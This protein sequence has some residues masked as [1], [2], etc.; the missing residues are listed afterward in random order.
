M[1]ENPL[2]PLDQ[3]VQSH[4]ITKKGNR[5]TPLYVAFTEHERLLGKPDKNQASIIQWISTLNMSTTAINDTND[6]YCRFPW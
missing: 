1:Y 6:K 5:T 2:N 4:G 3:N